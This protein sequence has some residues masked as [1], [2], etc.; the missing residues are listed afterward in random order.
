MIINAGK[1]AIGVAKKIGTKIKNWTTGET[2]KRKLVQKRADIDAH[3][4]LRADVAG[5]VIDKEVAKTMKA[6][7]RPTIGMTTGQKVGVG[8]VGALSVASLIPPSHRDEYEAQARQN[9]SRGTR[10]E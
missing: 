7:K 5:G 1:K 2:A 10:N 9:I 3:L 4:K 8:A 6:W